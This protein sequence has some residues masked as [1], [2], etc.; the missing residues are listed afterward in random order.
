M[1][2]LLS[3][4]TQPR[5]LHVATVTTRQDLRGR[6]S[7][8][9]LGG[10]SCHWRPGIEPPEFRSR[11]C[12]F[13]A[14]ELGQTDLLPPQELAQPRRS[15]PSVTKRAC[16]PQSSFAIFLMETTLED[17]SSSAVMCDRPL[18]RSSIRSLTHSLTHSL[19]YYLDERPVRRSLICQALC[20]ASAISRRA[21]VHTRLLSL[22]SRCSSKNTRIRSFQGAD[23]APL[24]QG[25]V[26]TR[27][28]LLGRPG[29][30]VPGRGGT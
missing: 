20:Q 21:E 16:D 8:I 14:G 15:V 1:Y 25:P 19:C 23:P 28:R 30:Q 9:L 29:K 12:R 4:V 22:R 17:I 24:L 5:F 6:R 3:E 2:H 7:R 26:A 13:L 18:I 27:T 10:T 11:L